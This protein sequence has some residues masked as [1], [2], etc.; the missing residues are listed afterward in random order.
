MFWKVKRMLGQGKE[1]VL[2]DHFKKHIKLICDACEIFSIA[3][4]NNDKIMISE[5]CEIEK[6]GDSIRREI[7]LKLY[8][9]AFLPGIRG[10]LYR[11]AETVDEV[12]DTIED[13]TVMY[14]LLPKIDDDIMNDCIRISEI[15]VK[16]SKDLLRAF[17][18]LEKEEDLSDKT[19]KIRAREEEVD[20][21]KRDMFKK[22]IKKDVN[23]FWE[24]IIMYN[25]IRHLTNVS[26]LIED[27]GDIIQT[28][29]VSLR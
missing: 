18:A 24:G 6:I 16:I 12:L 5:I 17:E 21:I 8:E 27:A 13:A 9:G 29:N 10:N 26:D 11:L 1:G 15:N 3:I 2:I 19:I 25:F 4:K 7:V 23:N 20:T 22:L 14:L 28:L